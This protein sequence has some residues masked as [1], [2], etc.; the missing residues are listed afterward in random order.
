MESYTLEGT[1]EEVA[2]HA[3]D[4]SG[5][6]VRLTVLTGGAREASDFSGV[7]SR[8][9]FGMFKGQPVP[10]DEDFRSAEFHGDNDDGLD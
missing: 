2:L 10:T 8:M 5:K 9:F 1:W 3:D 4:F 6:R 7:N